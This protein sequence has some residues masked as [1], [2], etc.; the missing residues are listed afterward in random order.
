LPH[1]NTETQRKSFLN[2][3]QKCGFDPSPILN[4]ENDHNEQLILKYK[5]VMFDDVNMQLSDSFHLNRKLV[6]D[7]VK[8]NVSDL[9][10]IYMNNINSNIDLILC[11]LLSHT[12]LSE[13]SPCLLVDVYNN[14]N[15]Y[16]ILVNDYRKTIHV[17]NNKEYNSYNKDRLVLIYTTFFVLMGLTVKL[18]KSMTMTLPEIQFNHKY[19]EA[20]KENIKSNIKLMQSYL[21]LISTFIDVGENVFDFITDDFIKETINDVCNNIEQTIAEANVRKFKYADTS[22][23]IPAILKCFENTEFLN[24]IHNKIS[25]IYKLTNM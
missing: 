17:I 18:N 5:K 14:T 8:D 15:K 10:S 12:E 13:L 21:K 3:L 9:L 1:I 25:M 11:N 16:K 24:T 2:T 22:H 23:C 6:I 19:N 7:I 20:D 4:F